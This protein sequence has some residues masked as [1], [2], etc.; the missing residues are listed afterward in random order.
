MNLI[1]QKKLNKIF[2]FDKY[3]EDYMIQCDLEAVELG[4]FQEDFK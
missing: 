2:D 3:N 1:T 4:L